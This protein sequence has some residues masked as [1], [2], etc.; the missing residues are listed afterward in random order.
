MCP[1]AA[2]KLCE[3]ASSA[4]FLERPVLSGFNDRKRYP[5]RR[6]VCNSR[7]GFVLVAKASKPRCAGNPAIR[8]DLGF[9]I[10]D[11]LVGAKPWKT[12]S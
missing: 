11:A 1:D 7:C 10:K 9:E 5:V 4:T 8:V 3:A 6:C 12:L 2:Q